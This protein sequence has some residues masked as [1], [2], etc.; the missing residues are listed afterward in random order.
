MSAEAEADDAPSQ[1]VPVRAARATV[2]TLR[3]SS[4]LI[5]TVVLI[6]E[7]TSVI[8]AQAEGR[9]AP[10]SVV[11]GQSVEAGDVLIEVDLRPAEARLAGVRAA[12]QRAQ[13][14][15]AKLE[16]GPRTEEVEAARQDTLQLAA[17]ARALEAKLDAMRALHE[18][19]DLSDVEFGQAQARFDDAEAESRAAEARLRL[20][21]AGPRA[22][23]IAEARAELAVAEADVAAQELEVEF[24]TIRSPID[25][26][27][28]QLAARAG[29]YVTQS[30]VLA[31]VAD[32]S[33]LFVQARIPSTHF[34]QV[35]PGAPAD[36]WTAPRADTALHGT[37]ARLGPRAN[38][39]TGDV[40]VF[41][42]IKNDGGQ[43][44]PELA[45]RVRVWLPEL[46][47]VLA[48]PVAAVADRDGTPVVTVIRDGKAFE[49]PVT[50]GISTKDQIQAVGG[51]EAG[52]WVAIE[53]GYGLPEGC[54]VRFISE[55][56]E[57][58]T[59]PGADD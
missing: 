15:L 38:P 14:T 7:R 9:I 8:A 54:P 52:D 33:E 45:C 16:H 10:I 24:C 25:G 44:V 49:Q 1:P 20:L 6:P 55:A 32:T 42:S 28:I 2:T 40:D 22:E 53:G 51:L 47:D 13:A 57:G 59:A 48:I 11:E 26:V 39:D 36:V 27:V 37:V 5:G 19:G 30:D 35:K 31:I 58:T 12:E 46:G 41:V 56:A 34:S 3:P 29:A 23:E 17:A 21:E 43:L 4:D 50:L 18:K